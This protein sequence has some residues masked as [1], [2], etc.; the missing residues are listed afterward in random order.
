MAAVAA[1]TATLNRYQRA[2]NRR[3]LRAFELQATRAAVE[4]GLD[5]DWAD[6]VNDVRGVLAGAAAIPYAEFREHRLALVTDESDARLA[7]LLRNLQYGPSALEDLDDY[8]PAVIRHRGRII[9]ETKSYPRHA[10]D[11]ARRDAHLLSLAGL[12]AATLALHLREGRRPEYAPVVRSA[13]V[14]P[15]AQ[16]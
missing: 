5:G 6:I 9:D 1:F 15:P 11:L 16:D 12:S 7:E 13:F 8:L 2:G 10:R 14:R 3:D 4:F